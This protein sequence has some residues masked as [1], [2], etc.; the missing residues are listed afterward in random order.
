MN[1][2]GGVLKG[3]ILDVPVENGLTTFLNPY[4]YLMI[5]RDLSLLESIDTFLIDGQLLVAFFK[6]LGIADLERKSFDMTSLAPEVFT[7]GA[8]CG[9]TVYLVGSTPD[10]IGVAAENIAARFPGLD[11]AGYH[12]GY[13]DDDV[14]ACKVIEEIKA[15]SISIVVVG[16][17]APRQEQFLVRLRE[18][19]WGGSGYTC[20][21]FFHQTAT[22]IDYYPRW[23]DR[24]NLRWLYRIYDEPKL[25]RRYFIL[26]PWALCLIVWDFKIQP[27]LR[28][29]FKEG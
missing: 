29:V 25:A 11:I 12:H 19:G 7:A 13:L 27:L 24:L 20:G 15:K 21:G 3:R 8:N 6:V 4:S 28:K 10:T 5:R 23:A 18:S 14:D 1:V 17:G 9:D 16:M 26:Y 22:R 2:I